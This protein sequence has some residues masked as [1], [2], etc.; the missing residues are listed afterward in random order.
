MGSHKSLKYLKRTK[1]RKDWAC[2]KCNR[3]INRGDEYYRESIGPND[4]MGLPMEAYCID[5][6]SKSGLEIK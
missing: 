3:Q 2:I 4:P 6:G 5:C 1:A